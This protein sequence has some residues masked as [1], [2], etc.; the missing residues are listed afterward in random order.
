MITYPIDHPTSPGFTGIKWSPRSAVATQ[1]SPFTFHEKT[2]VW[3]GQQRIVGIELPAMAMSDAKQ[4]S[5]FGLELNGSE[6]TFYLRDSLGK[7]AQGAVTGIGY[8]KG[9][10]QTGQDLITDGWAANVSG[11]FKKGDWIQVGTRL[12]TVLVD[13]DSNASGEATLSLWPKIRTAPADNLELPYGENAKGL[14]RLTSF[15]EFGW[16]VSRLMVGFTFQAKEVI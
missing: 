9:A 3:A 6:G 13:A 15:P 5:T 8:V 16:D 14:F 1:E 11:L 4:W 7:Y 10:S 12:H 2:Y